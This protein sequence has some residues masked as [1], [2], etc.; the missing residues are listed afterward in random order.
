M[1]NGQALITGLVHED[2]GTREALVLLLVK[3]S[4]VAVVFGCGTVGGAMT[5]TLYVGSMVGFIFST[6]LTS[7]GMEGNHTVAYAMV[8]MASFF[9][10]AAQ[11]PLTA[12]VMVVEFSM[13]GQMIYPLLIGVRRQ[14]AHGAS[15]CA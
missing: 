6:V 8:G 7:L 3:V 12:L 11:A 1:G 15:P 14:P 4:A 10:V 9:A 5:P 13:S 2:Y